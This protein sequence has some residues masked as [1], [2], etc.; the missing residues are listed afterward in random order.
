[1]AGKRHAV[2]D[3]VRPKGLRRSQLPLPE[4]SRWL[5]ARS[6]VFEHH[7]A[8]DKHPLFRSAGGFGFDV[9]SGLPGSQW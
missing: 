7:R 2:C 6:S 9:L 3:Y 4:G 1:H 8:E 5:S